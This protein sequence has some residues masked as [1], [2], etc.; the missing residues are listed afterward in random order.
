MQSVRFCSKGECRTSEEL[1]EAPTA[2][3]V[4]LLAITCGVARAR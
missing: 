1:P 2:A 3:G 4:A